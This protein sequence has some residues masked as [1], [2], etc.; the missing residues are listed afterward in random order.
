[1]V[2][3]AILISVSRLILVSRCEV[4]GDVGMK[5]GFLGVPLVK[6]PA[7]NEIG[8]R[9]EVVPKQDVIT[10]AVTAILEFAVPEVINHSR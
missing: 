7:P 9:I 10:R 3:E 1:M 2:I 5:R 6:V 8:S 4:T